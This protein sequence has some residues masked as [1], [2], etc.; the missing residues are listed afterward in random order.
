MPESVKFESRGLR[1]A[2]DLYL[3]DGASAGAPRPGLVLGHGFGGLK[4]GL[5]AQSEA[6]RQAGYVVLTIDYRYFGESEGE[7]RGQLFPLEQVE[8]MRNAIS[9][10]Q[11]R[12]E[13]DPEQIGI[14]GTS[15]GGAIVIYTAAV[16][17][18][19]RA[20][21]SQVPVVNGRQWMKALRAEGDWDVLLDRLDADRVQRYER[22]KSEYV[23]AGGA[24]IE[25]AMPTSESERRR[26]E[27][28]GMPP[29]GD[30]DR[31][32]TLESI[33]RVIEFFPEHMID[34]IGPRPLC[35]ITTAKRDVVHPLDQIQAAYKRANE[36]KELLLLP[37][38][39]YDVYSGPGVD[40]ANQT[41][42]EWF[43]RHLP[44]SASVSSPLAAAR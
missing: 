29:R 21:V 2:A 43:Q 27:A 10:L 28:E 42:I 19:V 37:L 5:V 35:I 33:E 16:D 24:F 18:R 34:L 30:P 13:V 15:F 1:C 38:A 40:L 20:V 41:A 25:A 3:P 23:P 26:L 44:V 11:H 14:W 32:L 7:P 6:F 36:P 4:S 39:Q 31:R 12:G 22:R 8:D 17:R 9:Y